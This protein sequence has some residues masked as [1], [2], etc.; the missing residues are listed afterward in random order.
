[1][2][3]T[4]YTAEETNWNSFAPITPDD[5]RGY[6]WIAVL[7]CLTI[8]ILVLTTRLWIKKNMLGWDDGFF[9][10]ASVATMPPGK[11]HRLHS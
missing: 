10:A 7:Y 5:H 2:S 1:M 8:S 9:I 6:L 3:A 11:Q 4:R